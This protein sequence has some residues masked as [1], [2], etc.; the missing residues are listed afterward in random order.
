MQT[1]QDMLAKAAPD[2]DPRHILAL[3]RS[4][5]GRNG[6]DDLDPEQAAFCIAMAGACVKVF[7][8]DLV[9]GIARERG[10]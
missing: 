10:I 1:Y 9:E 7:G 6:L 8:A 5:D 3:L 2:T 4:P